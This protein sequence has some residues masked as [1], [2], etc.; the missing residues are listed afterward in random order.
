MALFGR[1]HGSRPAIK[2][3]T[4][5]VLIGTGRAPRSRGDHLPRRGRLHRRAPARQRDVRASTSRRTSRAATSRSTPWPT[6]PAATRLVDPF[7]GQ[8]DLDARAVRAVGDPRGALPRGRPALHARGALR[9]HPRVRARPGDRRPPSPR[10]LDTFRKVSAERVR[11]E[12]C[13]LLWRAAPVAGARAHA[14]DRPPRARSM[15]GAARGRRP[16]RRTASTATTSGS[17]RS[18][19]VDAA[20]AARWSCAW[21]RC[22]TTWASRAPPSARGRRARRAHFFRHESVGRARWPTRS[23]AA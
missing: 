8:A 15:P 17:T 16:R 11:D 10:A 5:T 14:R 21:R 19:T 7:G 9:R 18:R 22:C 23:C 20:P 4:V 3:G 1:R 12:L 2:H 13:K 6:I